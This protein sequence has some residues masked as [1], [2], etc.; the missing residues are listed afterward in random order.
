LTHAIDKSQYR[1][2]KSPIATQS[3]D[4]IEV[5]ELFWFGCAHCYALEPDLA[6]WQETLNADVQFSKVPATFSRRWEFHA[7]AFYTMLDL[8][9][10]KQ[11]S[12]A[13]FYEIHG[14]RKAMSNLG[15]LS[16]FLGNYGLSNT[17]VEQGFNSFSVDTKFRASQ[18]LSKEIVGKGA[19]AEVPGMLID[20]RYFTN[21]S[22][23]GSKAALFDV[24]NELI[25][26]SRKP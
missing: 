4:K 26:M 22:M 17:Q 18:R 8:G 25:E 24:V 12:N 23:A 10:L 1:E 15:T 3:K 6:K 7:K 16:H 21:A 9:V 11:A 14:N 20:G 5:T 2:L 13:F 19:P